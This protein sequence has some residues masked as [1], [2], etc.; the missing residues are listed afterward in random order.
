[1]LKVSIFWKK[2]KLLNLSLLTCKKDK[3]GLQVEQK[4]NIDLSPPKEGR[5]TQITVNFYVWGKVKI[6][7]PLLLSQSISPSHSI[8][9]TDWHHHARL[10]TIKTNMKVSDSRKNKQK[11]MYLI[12]G[13]ETEAIYIY[14]LF[15]ICFIREAI[16]QQLSLFFS[17]SAISGRVN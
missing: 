1:M 4:T 16:I 17:I 6:Y 13:C 14:L 11:I 12:L 10:V 9:M 5:G 8:G 7:L 3:W 15:T 2:I